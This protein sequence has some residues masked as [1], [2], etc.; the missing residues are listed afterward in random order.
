MDNFFLIILFCLVGGLFIGLGVPLAK[1]R[2][3]PNALYGVRLPST[4]ANRDIWYEVNEQSG[5]DLVCLGAVILVCAVVVP[6]I[7]LMPARAYGVILVMVTL[8]GTLVMC[9]RVFWLAG[10]AKRRRGGA[11]GGGGGRGG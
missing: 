1:R 11:G 4:L 10:R 9:G 6:F 3:P 8:V 2:V 7:P 5:K